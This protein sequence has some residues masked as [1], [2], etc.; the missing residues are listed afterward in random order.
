MD[1]NRRDLTKTHPDNFKVIIY[2]LESFGRF[3][4]QCVEY[5]SVVPSLWKKPYFLTF[6]DLPK[7]VRWASDPDPAEVVARR[8]FFQHNPLPGAVVDKEQW[9]LLNPDDYW[10]PGFTVVNLRDDFV[11]VTR[12]L[13]G[14]KTKFEQVM[15][16]MTY[17]GTGKSGC[18]YQCVPPMS[19][20]RTLCTFL[21]SRM[22]FQSPLPHV[23][24]QLNADVIQQEERA[25]A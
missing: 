11:D 19:V 24:R 18:L 8:E 4:H 21:Q 14:M 16:R 15:D 12:L 3:K 25:S 10:R 17:S 2:I 1:S 5:I 6:D 20:F 9:V 7:T 23:D 22:K 13:E